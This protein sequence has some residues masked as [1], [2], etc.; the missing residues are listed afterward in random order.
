[1]RGKTILSGAVGI[2]LGVVLVFLI[3]GILV[4][5][6]S[7]AMMTKSNGWFTYTEC[8]KVGINIL[9][10]AVCA[11]ALPG[12]NV[13]QEAVYWQSYFDGAGHRLTGQ[14]GY[15]LQFPP[16]GLP[17]NSAFWSVT[18]YYINHTMVNNPIN[19]Y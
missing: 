3:G 13:P 14:H 10:Q 16:G 18:M 19:R 4:S 12:V 15:I 5:A 8:G 2:A 7:S 9:E 6:E 1:M 17:P 11:A